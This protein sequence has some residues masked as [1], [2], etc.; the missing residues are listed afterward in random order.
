MGDVSSKIPSSGDC[1]TGNEYGPTRF[2]ESDLDPGP[3]LGDLGPI[4]IFGDLGR[5]I[6]IGDLGPIINDVGAGIV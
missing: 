3:K 2:G 4:P 5:D 1:D 6:K